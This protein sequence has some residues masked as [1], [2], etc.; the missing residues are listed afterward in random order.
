MSSEQRYIVYSMVSMGYHIKAEKRHNSG[1][2]KRASSFIELSKTA[3]SRIADYLLSDALI[4]FQLHGDADTLETMPPSHIIVVDEGLEVASSK[5][6]DRLL[7]WAGDYRM[8]RHGAVDRQELY[9][10][11]TDEDA[12]NSALTEMKRFGG[13]KATQY[14]SANA[15][16]AQKSKH[17]SQ[18]RKKN[19]ANAN[20]AQQQQRPYG[21]GKSNSGWV[22]VGN[23]S[24][25]VAMMPKKKAERLDIKLGGF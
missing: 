3:H 24:T 14:D 19:K 8:Y 16:S 12:R 25:T 2:G 22:D 17:K 13:R 7:A 4:E 15:S 6:Q 20:K 18:Q 10:V 5:V 9:I 11:F 1:K 21:G 23:V